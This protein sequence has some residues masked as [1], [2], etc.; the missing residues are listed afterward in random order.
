MMT[1]QL[2][3]ATLQPGT[4]DPALLAHLRGCD[5]CLDHALSVD[6]DLF[7]RSIGGE[8]MLP[9]GGVDAFVD[10]V[11][12]QVRSRETETATL[13]RQTPWWQRAAIAAMVASAVA[14]ATLVGIHEQRPAG[15][16]S[17]HVAA[18]RAIPAASK[19]VVE[20]YESKDATIIE[21]PSDSKDVQVV[22]IFDEK[23]PADL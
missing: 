1:C 4:T 12:T 16:P 18:A 6:P 2:F 8:E 10:D 11:M 22:M 13:P 19:P 14:A 5:A 21:V 9:P 23:L 15:A 3:R 7:F 17:A 20:N